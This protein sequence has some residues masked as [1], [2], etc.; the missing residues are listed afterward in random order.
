MQTRKLHDQC[1]ENV[2]TTGTT[3]Q[4][5]PADTMENAKNRVAAHKIRTAARKSSRI[6]SSKQVLFSISFLFLLFSRNGE[7]HHSAS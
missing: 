5:K 1:N 2:G 7:N 4:R 6:G 3:K